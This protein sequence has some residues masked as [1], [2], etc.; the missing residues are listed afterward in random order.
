MTFPQVLALPD[1]S[2]HFEPE[3]DV[4]GNG[5][6]VVL[7]KKGKPIAFTSQA[8]GPRNQALSTYERELIVIVHAIKKWQNYLQGHHF[9]IKLTIIVWNTS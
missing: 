3:R 7:Q 2:P 4:L 9:V 6:G 5:I 1:F 8:L